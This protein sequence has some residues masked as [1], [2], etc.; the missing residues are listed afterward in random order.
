MPLSACSLCPVVY[1]GRA[2]GGRQAAQKKYEN[3]GSA[4][5]LN[6]THYLHAFNWVWASLRFN[7][8]ELI[9]HAGLDM[10]MYLRM[11]VMA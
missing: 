3:V 7:E 8:K 1:R 2:W 11:F 10:V 4:V 6:P 9:Q 5:N